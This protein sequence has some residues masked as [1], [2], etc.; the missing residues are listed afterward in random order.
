MSAPGSIAGALAAGK[1]LRLMTHVVAG[2]PDPAES[3]R[4]VATMAAQGADFIELQIPFSD[5]MADGPTI[6]MANQAALD[7]GVGVQDAFDLMGRLSPAVKVPLLFMTYLNVPWR[8]GVGRFVE[9]ARERGAKGI[10][11]PDL[12]FD[13]DLPEYVERCH[14]LGVDP[15]FVVSPDTPT[16]RL[17]RIGKLGRGFIY[18]TLKIGIT[19]G[20]AGPSEKGLSFLKAL[21]Q[22]V[23]LPI[24]AGFGIS[25]PEAIR[26]VR[27]L[28]DIAVVG[29]QLIR[30][31]QRGGVAAVGAFVR[32]LKEACA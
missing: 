20:V 13:E 9:R 16:D 12:P 6:M 4:L 23:P 28:C 22:L 19:G 11:L 10:I 5:P 29:S 15:I 21:R 26:Q 31:H 18:A 17:A 24:A 25:G 2:Y 1:G 8:M 32:S 27:G 7:A 30:E 3:E 14:A